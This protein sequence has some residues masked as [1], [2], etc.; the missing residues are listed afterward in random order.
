MP[1][2]TLLRISEFAKANWKIIFIITIVVLWS[3]ACYN[4]GKRTVRREWDKAIADA[5][6][7][8]REVE[9][10]NNIKSNIL[11]ANHENKIN[12]IDLVYADAINSLLNT[13]N[14]S[15]RAST[16]TT[17]KP[18]GCA[19]S[20]RVY[21]ANNRIRIAREAERNTAKLIDLQ[22]WVKEFCR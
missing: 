3:L 20:N 17:S 19:T 9:F 7:K 16:S 5:T 12:A 18:D 13:S 14:D 10:D 1:I 21:K 22:G 2:L 6:I 8:A 11:G 15:V 4:S